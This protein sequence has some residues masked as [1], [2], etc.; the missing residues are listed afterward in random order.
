MFSSLLLILKRM[1]SSRRNPKRNASR[2]NE[3][4]DGKPE[5]TRVG[6]NKDNKSDW[7]HDLCTVKLENDNCRYL[8]VSHYGDSV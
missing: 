2:S 5:E 8:M 3:N 1:N 6:S 7:R 4:K